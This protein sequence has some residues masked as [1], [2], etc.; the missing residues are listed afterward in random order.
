[1]HIM[2]R[3]QQESHLQNEAILLATQLFG[4]SNQSLIQEF[5]RDY[6]SLVELGYPSARVKQA[7]LLFRSDPSNEKRIDYLVACECLLQE[8]PNQEVQEALNTF[9]QNVQVAKAY[10]NGFR[11]LLEFG[12]PK[13]DIKAALLMSNNDPHLA[14]QHLL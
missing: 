14:L 13:G 4:Q 9:N 11:T 2:A 7:M 5:A 6:Q 12:F 8:Y 10:L 3:Q 1:M